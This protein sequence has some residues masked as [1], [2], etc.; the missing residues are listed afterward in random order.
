MN[1]ISF[2]IKCDFKIKI[3]IFFYFEII[4]FLVTNLTL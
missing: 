1:V 2:D 4:S 3:K